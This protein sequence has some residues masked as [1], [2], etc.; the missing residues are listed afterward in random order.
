[1]ERHDIQSERRKHYVND[2]VSIAVRQRNNDKN[3]IPGDSRRWFLT[4]RGYAQLTE[5]C[6]F[7]IE[8][9]PALVVAERR[10]CPP[11]VSGGLKKAR[12]PAGGVQMIIP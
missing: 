4:K 9:L 2:E 3:N 1:M 7:A 6:K 12:I 5:A 10:A 8:G 11:R